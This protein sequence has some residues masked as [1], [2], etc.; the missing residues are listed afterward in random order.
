[1]NVAEQ[2]PAAPLRGI[3]LTSI[4]DLDTVL[5]LI[6][7]SEEKLTVR[8]VIQSDVSMDSY[9]QAIEK[10]RPHAYI[11]VE[12]LDSHT[13]AE[14]D[15]GELRSLTAE[16]VDALGDE[17]DVWEVGNE[18]NG[19]WLGSSPEQI[20]AKASAVKEIVSQSGG[21]TAITLNY[22]SH[23]GC[24][25]QPWERLSTYARSMPD[26]LRDVDYLFLSVYEMS[27]TPAQHP[28]A[29]DLAGALNSLGEIFPNARLGIGEISGYDP[30][31]PDSKTIDTEGRQAGNRRIATYYYGLHDE[32]EAKVGT[33]YVG[34]YFW[35]HFREDAVE[36]DMWPLLK[37]L[38]EGL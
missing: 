35:W 17:V 9:R 5:G 36:G 11:M 13:W 3:T 6:E 8:L 34:G 22:W 1:M 21:R 32:L 38:L 31:T 4:G 19:S 7:S 15:I 16:A 18:L 25:A 24:Y 28:S 37:E 27:C 29:D 10:L 14:A 12:I 2:A 26:D 20:N 30:S 23:E 33:R